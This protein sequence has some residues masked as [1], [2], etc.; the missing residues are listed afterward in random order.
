MPGPRTFSLASCARSLA[1][2]RPALLP[3][4]GGL[5]A[6]LGTRAKSR[7]AAEAGCEVRGRGRAHDARERRRRASER[8]RNAA[9]GGGAARARQP[10]ARRPAVGR[11]ESRDPLT[12]AHASLR[13]RLCQLPRPK[14]G[15]YGM[16][17]RPPPPLARRRGQ[18]L[19]PGRRCGPRAT[20]HGCRMRGQQQSL[21]RLG[22]KQQQQQ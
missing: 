11:A 2:A 3:P 14:Y 20:R 8:Q 16:H 4:S 12:C 22:G 17:A 21:H 10:R 13:R 15:Q 9:K 5:P 6:R 18:G 1:R 19:R 7:A